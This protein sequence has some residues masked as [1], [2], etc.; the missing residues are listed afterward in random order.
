LGASVGDIPETSGGSA[1]SR[2]AY[3]MN[4]VLKILNAKSGETTIDNP[5]KWHMMII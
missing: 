5:S 4:Y 3:M 2:N 1:T